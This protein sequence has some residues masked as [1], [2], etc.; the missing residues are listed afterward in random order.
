MESVPEGWVGGRIRKRYLTRGEE[1]LKSEMRFL[2]A[3][4]MVGGWWHSRPPAHGREE[5]F[6]SQ[7]SG[8]REGYRESLL[9]LEGAS[10]VMRRPK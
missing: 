6:N 7:V 8:E 9:V 3:M 2:L 10:Q 4:D 1:G 5:E